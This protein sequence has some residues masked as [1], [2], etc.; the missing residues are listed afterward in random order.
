MLIMGVV[1]L[2]QKVL[3]IIKNDK[4]YSEDKCNF[5]LSLDL[6]DVEDYIKRLSSNNNMKT[7][8]DLRNNCQF[9][10]VIIILF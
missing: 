8:N 5:R 6:G 7:Y 2:E 4:R 9:F 10:F 1:V 3:K